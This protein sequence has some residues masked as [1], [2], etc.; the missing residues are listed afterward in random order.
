MASNGSERDAQ[1]ALS[2]LL[3]FGTFEDYQRE[4]E[5]LMN[6]V[7][8]IPNSL[9]IFYFFSGLKLHLQHEFF[10]SRLTTLGDAF[11]LARI[12]EARYEDERSTTAIA[13]PTSPILTMGG[14]QNKASGSSTT[15]EVA[16]RRYEK[17]N[18]SSFSCRELWG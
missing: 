7:T 11:S 4:F 18:H 17:G 15:P 8:D 5:K 3:Q 13:K 16:H 10:V 12:V 1:Y 2:K 14:S 9:L 6:R